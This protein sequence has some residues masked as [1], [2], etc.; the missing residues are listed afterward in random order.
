[1]LAQAVR[2]TMLHSSNAPRTQC[3]YRRCRRRV[4]AQVPREQDSYSRH[5]DR[6]LRQECSS[7]AWVPCS[8]FTSLTVRGYECRLKTV[9]CH[10][11]E[12]LAATEGLYRS[13]VRAE[14][15]VRK[16]LMEAFHQAVTD[17]GD[18]SQ[19]EESVNARALNIED[20]F[21]SMASVSELLFPQQYTDVRSSAFPDFHGPHK[22]RQ[23][24]VRHNSR[25]DGRL[26]RALPPPYA[27]VNSISRSS[28][29][30]VAACV[31][32]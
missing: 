17:N 15:R 4:H 5:L 7:P 27:N 11:A 20:A 1:M 14:D 25:F 16:L 24:V 8:P 3:V 12:A 32:A 13:A 6:S 31:D 26:S 19:T 10:N 30:C 23:S 9:L 2:C 29:I 21:F 28:W 18:G 22:H